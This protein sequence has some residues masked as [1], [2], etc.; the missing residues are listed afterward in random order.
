MTPTPETGTVEF[1]TTLAV[2]DWERLREELVA[3]EFHNGRTTDQLRRSFENSRHVALAYDGD[4][5]IGT[6]RAL[7]DDV[8]NAYV[9]DVW[10]QSG[11]RRRGI[12]TE[13]MRLLVDAVAG[14]HIYLQ[15]D[16]SAGFY[17]RLGF[18][19]QPRGMHLI[20][21]EYLRE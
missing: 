11:Y 15:A 3:D 9:V 1:R 7:S 20:S 21:G 18:V 6:G 4:R 8:G 5:C 10:T 12:A 13:L 17:E 19:E 14:Q 16:D 2:V